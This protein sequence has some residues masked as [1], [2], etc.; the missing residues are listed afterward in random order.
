VDAG[1]YGRRRVE[2]VESRPLDAVVFRWRQ[3]RIQLIAQGLPAGV[4][5]FAGDAIRKDGEGNRTEA[6]ESG[7]RL[8]FFSCCRPR[9]LLDGLQRADGGDYVAG[10]GLLAAGDAAGWMCRLVIGRGLVFCC[11]RLRRGTTVA[12]GLFRGVEKAGLASGGFYLL[13]M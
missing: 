5:V 3:Q 11:G 10:F 4:L 7:E 12:G 9:I 1:Y 6:R 8:F 13:D 2:G